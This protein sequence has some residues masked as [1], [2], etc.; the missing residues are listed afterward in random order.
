[1]RL[2]TKQATSNTRIFLGLTAL[3]ALLPRYQDMVKLIQESKQKYGVAPT[4]VQYSIA[5]GALSKVGLYDDLLRLISTSK[6]EFDARAYTVLLASLPREH[7]FRRYYV[8][9]VIS[10]FNRSGVEADLYLLRGI[11]A[12]YAFPT[13]PPFPLL[14]FPLFLPFITFASTFA[15]LQCCAVK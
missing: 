2:P 4:V 12:A 6:V 9:Q 3:C 15:L 11:L 10:H 1:M 7:P 5:F 8:S 13:P 14:P